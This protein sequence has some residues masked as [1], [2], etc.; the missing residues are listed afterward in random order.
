M[1]RFIPTRPPITASFI[2]LKVAV[3]IANLYGGG[4]ENTN[5]ST[6]LNS[7]DNL[8]IPMHS[9]GS[10]YVSP[11]SFSFSIPVT[12]SV[13]EPLRYLNTDRSVPSSFYKSYRTI[14]PLPANLLPLLFPQTQKKRKFHCGW[15]PSP[16]ISTTATAA[17]VKRKVHTPPAGSSP[18][19]IK[20]TTPYH[21]SPQTYSIFHT[22]HTEKTANYTVGGS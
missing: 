19:S 17:T 1:R 20:L 8:S 21:H 9:T 14:P 10:N 16:P 15:D 4:T 18:T 5:N 6:N 11:W 22:P 13:G 2:T 12:A 3:S 7:I